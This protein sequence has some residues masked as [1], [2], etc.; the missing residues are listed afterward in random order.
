M[1]PEEQEALSRQAKAA[2]T[3]KRRTRERLI[4]A[5][6]ELMGLRDPDD[7]SLPSDP[8]DTTVEAIAERADVSTATFYT[9]FRSRNQLC[10][11]AV[12]ELVVVPLERQGVAAWPYDE[13]I[14]AI[15]ERCEGRAALVRG[16]MLQ[17]LENQWFRYEL[18]QDLVGRIERLLREGR[19]LQQYTPQDAMSGKYG[20]YI[21][22]MPLIALRLLDVIAREE[23]IRHMELSLLKSVVFPERE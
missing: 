20:A 12:I 23:P 18:G 11:A 22:L 3:K 7:D 2:E 14:A 17:R 9:V 15:L 6:D 13:T 8:W 5:V 10:E 16:A 4:R 1:A 21:D 19:E